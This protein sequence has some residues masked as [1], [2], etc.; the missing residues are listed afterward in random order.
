M[1]LD[2]GCSGCFGVVIIVVVIYVA[3][4]IF[5]KCDESLKEQAR[6]SEEE[7]P[8]VLKVLLESS[9]GTIFYDTGTGVEYIGLQAGYAFVM[10]P[11]YAPDGSLVLYEDSLQVDSVGSLQVDSIY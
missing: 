5:V 3:C 2:D 1:T 11:R 7:N 9:R 6:K 8:P 4:C 10:F